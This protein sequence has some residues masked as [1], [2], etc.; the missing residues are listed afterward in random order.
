MNIVWNLWKN[1]GTGNKGRIL[2][3]SVDTSVQSSNMTM[4]NTLQ[5]SKYKMNLSVHEV[6]EIYYYCWPKFN[7]T[8]YFPFHIWM[9]ETENKQ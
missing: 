3:R 1:E 4:E 7:I 9:L 2:P 8:M 5:S 6:W